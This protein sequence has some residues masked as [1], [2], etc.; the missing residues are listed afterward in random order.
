M[1][2]NGL[3]QLRQMYEYTIRCGPYSE[4]FSTSAE[5]H[6]GQSKRPAPRP[7]ALRLLTFQASL[8]LVP[9]VPRQLSVLPSVIALVALYRDFYAASLEQ[10]DDAVQVPLAHLLVAHARQTFRPQGLDAGFRVWAEPAEHL[11]QELVHALLQELATPFLVGYLPDEALGVGACQLLLVQDA[12]RPPGERLV[13]GVLNGLEHDVHGGPDERE[14]GD[15][16]RPARPRLV[17]KAD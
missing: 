17:Q 6:Q 3:L 11:G 14:R 15:D 9:L 12:V 16:V 7:R 4:T 10:G 8:E 1:T 5:S 13:A 2:S